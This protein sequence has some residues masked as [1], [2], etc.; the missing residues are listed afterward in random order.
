MLLSEAIEVL[1][2]AVET[3]DPA[4][5]SG[6]DAARLVTLFESGERLCAAGKTLMLTRVVECNEWSAGGARSAPEWLS[7]LAGVSPG[8]AR[9]TLETADQLASQ[10]EVAHALRS[11]EIST[12]QAAE[13]ASAVAHNPACAPR[14][15]DDAKTRGFKGL[16]QSCRVAR[17][18]AKSREEDQANY[19]RQRERRYCRTWTDAD[20]S[21]RI[22]A[23]MDPLSFV[24][25]KACLHPFEEEAFNAFRKAGTREPTDRYRADALLALAET[26]VA[27]RET[28]HTAGDATLFSAGD[29]SHA[30]SIRGGSAA[31]P[32]DGSGKAKV[33]AKLIVVVDRQALLRGYPEDGE[34]CEIEGFG[35]I[36]L[37]AAREIMQDAFLAAV[38]TDGVDIRRVVHL[39]RHPTEMQRTALQ[40]R[41]PCC[42][43]PGCE[44]TGGESQPIATRW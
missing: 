29:T 15:L 41:D 39:G 26:A 44:C 7:Q 43:I 27:N 4:C 37:A 17:L 6:A 32:A 1:A 8:A 5:T 22:D 18:A 24:R 2:K 35:P 38:V 10:P 30:T 3:L 9:R 28:V 20:G 40:V 31:S 42:V 23:R 34:R 16:R 19:D 11:G 12:A 14:L 36:P 13:I 25:F 21:G 33:P